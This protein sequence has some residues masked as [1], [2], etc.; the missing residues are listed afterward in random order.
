M[1]PPTGIAALFG[2]GILI[3]GVVVVVELP[4]RD[5][6]RPV[7]RQQEPALGL[8]AGRCVGGLELDGAV[9]QV[10][11]VAEERLGASQSRRG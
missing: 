2:V 8:T 10:E 1:M 6:R 11:P 7:L 9:G 3:V 4:A 5:D